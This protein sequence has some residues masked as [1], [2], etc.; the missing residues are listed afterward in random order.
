LRTAQLLC[1]AANEDAPELAAQRFLQALYQIELERV[2]ASG[3]RRSRVDL[4]G[5]LVQS[6]GGAI[7]DAA[8]RAVLSALGLLS[9][10]SH[11]LCHGRLGVVVG[12][13]QSARRPF[14]L[15]AGQIVTPQEAVSPCSPLG[16][17]PWAKS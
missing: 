6:L 11:V 4:Q 12:Q 1:C 5:F 8:G 14:V 15:M 7:D 3:P 10:G 9:S 17:T 13:G 2:P 16:M